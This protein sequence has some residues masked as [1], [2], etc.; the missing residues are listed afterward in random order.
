M[1]A[2]LSYITIEDFVTV[3]GEKCSAIPLSYQVFGLP[4]HT[5]PIVLINHALTGNSQVTGVGGWWSRLVGDGNCVDTQR[6]TVV[7]FNAP[8]N[9]FDGVEANLT[10]D[11]KKFIARD[12][13]AIFAQGLEQLGVYKLYAVVGGSLGG[14]IAWEMAALC[15]DLIENL[16]PV[17]TD[18]KS[19]DWLRA[20]CLIQERI[21]LNSNDPIHDAR[22]HAMLIYRTAESFKLKFNRSVNEELGVYNIESWLLHH[23]KKLKERFALE[24]YKSLNHVLANIDITKGRGS[25]KEV[26]KTIKAK[27]HIISVD[28]DTFFTA[29]ENMATVTE[30]REIGHDVTY[31]VIHSVH[32]H[33]AFLI[34]YEQLTN[35]LAPVFTN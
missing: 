23:G 5:A 25:F 35:L 3:S 27:I 10:Q 2:R 28:T 33:D 9:G 30:L 21:L 7:I 26:A 22:L 1:V 20:N 14:G 32:G 11:Y 13:A 12:M 29:S 17:A 34:E 8:G 31:G 6:F 24:A 19:S 18:W 16:I 4:L 15:P